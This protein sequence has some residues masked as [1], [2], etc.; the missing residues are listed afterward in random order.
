MES[1]ALLARGLHAFVHGVI[2]Q[3][4]G[5]DGVRAVDAQARVR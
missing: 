1:A 2:S 4:L 3:P 5:V